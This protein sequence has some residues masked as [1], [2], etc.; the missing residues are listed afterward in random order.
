MITFGYI[1]LSNICQACP[2]SLQPLLDTFQ[3]ALVHV[4]VCIKFVLISPVSFL[5]FKNVAAG[6][7]RTTQQLARAAH[8]PSP[9]HS[10]ALGPA[11]LSSPPLLRLGP[12]RA[13]GQ[14]GLAASSE[15]P[16]ALWPVCILRDG[17][18]PRCVRSLPNFCFMTCITRG[19]VAPRGFT[20]RALKYL[21]SSVAEL[22]TNLGGS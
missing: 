19:P 14:R 2:E 21:T 16:A 11:C 5:R 6:K 15:V 13:P 22:P 20:R 1:E 12:G 4:C 10:A 18:D 9:S 7:F 17:V 8:P 3:T